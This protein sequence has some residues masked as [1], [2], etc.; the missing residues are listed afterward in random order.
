[1]ESEMA[2]LLFFVG[3]LAAY[4]FLLPVA[5]EKLMFYS[6]RIHMDEERRKSK[7]SLEV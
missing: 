1:M 4:V 7:K 5:L 3:L 2:S 6:A